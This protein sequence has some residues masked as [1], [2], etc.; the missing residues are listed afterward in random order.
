MRTLNL[1]VM[2]FNIWEKVPQNRDEIL[3][4][5]MRFGRASPFSKENLYVI[6]RGDLKDGV[7]TVESSATPYFSGNSASVSFG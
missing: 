5:L 1:F 2:L 6:K 3:I 4:A 7:A